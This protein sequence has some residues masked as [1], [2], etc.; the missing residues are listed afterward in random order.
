MNDNINRLSYNDKELIKNGFDI[1]FCLAMNLFVW[2]TV[3]FVKNLNK[4]TEL[5]GILYITN[6]FVHPVVKPTNKDMLRL[7]RDG[8][9]KLLT[10]GGFEIEKIQSL[11]AINDGVINFYNGQLMRYAKGYQYHNE[12]GQFITCKKIT[13]L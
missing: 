10:V 12:I 2:D 9:I 7:T 1:V 4:F 8:I 3:N 5:D 11:N 6:Y 13:T